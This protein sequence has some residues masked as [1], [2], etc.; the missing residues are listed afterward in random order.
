MVNPDERGVGLSESCVVRGWPF[1]PTYGVSIEVLEEF[2]IVDPANA[3]DKFSTIG[4][5]SGQ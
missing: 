2:V 1:S 3:A 4:N 5:G